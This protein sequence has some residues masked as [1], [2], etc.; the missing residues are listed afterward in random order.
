MKLRFWRKDPEPEPEPPPWAGYTPTADMVDV[1][2]AMEWPATEIVWVTRCVEL[3]RRI[4]E[5]EVALVE[6]KRAAAS[7]STRADRR[8]DK[9]DTVSTRMSTKLSTPMSTK[10]RPVARRRKWREIK[11]NQ[12]ARLKLVHPTKDAS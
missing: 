8:M 11:R 3:R 9:T 4:A 6:A 7:V 1:M 12:R 2:I 5:L 10:K